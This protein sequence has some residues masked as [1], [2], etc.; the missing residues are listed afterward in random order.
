MKKPN[1]RVII[2]MLLVSVAGTAV[3]YQ[4]TASKKTVPQNTNDQAVTLTV[5]VDAKFGN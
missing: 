3:V 2:L 5:K 1:R 4:M